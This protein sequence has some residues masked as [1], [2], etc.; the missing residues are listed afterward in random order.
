VSASADRQLAA[1]LLVRVEE[2]AY[3]SRLLAGAVP[4]GVRTRV[5]GALRWQRTLDAALAVPLRR[6]L[7][8][9]DP[10]VRAVLRVGLLEAAVLGVPVAV[11]TDAAVRT[12]RRLGKSS[13]AGLVNAVLRRAAPVWSALREQA[14]P[15]IRS[16]HPEW[17]YRRWAAAFGEETAQRVMAAD[18]E[19]AP[20]WVWWRDEAARDAA[21]AS[22]LELQLHPWCPGAWTAREQAGELLAAVAAGA[23]YVQDPSSQLVAHLAMAI[24]GSSARVADLCAAPGGKLALWRRLG[25]EIPPLALDRHLGRLSLAGALLARVGGACLVAADATAPPMRAGSLDL[26]LVDAPCSGTGTLR[27][28]PELKWRLR[29]EAIAEL[30]GLQARI[31]DAARE[32]MAPGGVMLYTTCS[33]EPEENERLLAGTPE[34]LDRVELAARL[35]KGVPAIPTAAGG[36]RILPC[37]DGDGF[38]MHAV[39]R[40]G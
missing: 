4:A 35:P 31:R 33:I 14:D 40:R 34:G 21:A 1:R 23:A 7:D 25:G 32:L 2:G 10:E 18:Q 12:V 26:V 24:A 11:A 13:A 30:A 15:H 8:R 3:S 38:T 5:L 29:P 27:R 9:L 22:G 16:S 39:R 17:L 19:P 37:L 20:V 6:P 36:I 28:H